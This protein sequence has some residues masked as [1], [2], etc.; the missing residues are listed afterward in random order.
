MFR[1]AGS[2]P[3][4]LPSVM[5]LLDELEFELL[6]EL[7]EDLVSLV[8]VVF[9]DFLIVFFRNEVLSSLTFFSFSSIPS[10]M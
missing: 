2:T 1:C 8:V 5:K 7:L 6:D 9:S 10:V 4:I 3:A